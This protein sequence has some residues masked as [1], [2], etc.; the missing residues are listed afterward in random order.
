[1]NRNK[2]QICSGHE[3]R[4]ICAKQGT[5]NLW[6]ENEARVACYQMGMEWEEGSGI[7]VMVIFIIKRFILYSD[8]ELKISGSY[9]NKFYS[10]NLSCSGLEEKLINCLSDDQNIYYCNYNSYG[11]IYATAKCIE[12]I[13]YHQLIINLLQIYIVIANLFCISGSFSLVDKILKI[14]A[15]GQW[16]TFCSNTWTLGQAN[17]ACRQL[18][19]NPIGMIISI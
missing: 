14:C 18:G 8:I 12:G 11:Y 5:T 6:S 2:L 9:S 19:R 4:Y 10:K 15:F 16:H 7:V 13:L 3:W 17:V 1:M